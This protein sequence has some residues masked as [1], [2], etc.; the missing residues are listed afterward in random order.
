[1]LHGALA[2]DEGE[3]P[4]PL[5]GD[6]RG[7][8]RPQGGYE[9]CLGRGARTAYLYALAPGA[10]ERVASLPT[11]A[12]GD[13]LLFEEVL[14]P[15][16]GDTADADPAHRQV[17]QLEAAEPTGDR[18]YRDRLTMDA[19]LQP[20]RAGDTPLPLLRVTW[21][22]SDALYRPFDHRLGGH[23]VQPRCYAAKQ[24][25]PRDRQ[26]DQLGPRMTRTAGSWNGKATGRWRCGP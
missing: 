14:G 26:R 8:R 18:A 9:A 7:D 24:Q 4:Q 25:Q 2:S 10:G 13:F 21:R 5:A 1:M 3:A 20:F 17:V 15:T 22:R 12:P 6:T 11:L 23:P 19:A 16:T